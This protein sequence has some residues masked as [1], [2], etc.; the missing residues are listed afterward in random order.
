VHLAKL[1]VPEQTLKLAEFCWPFDFLFLEQRTPLL[2]SHVCRQISIEL[3]KFVWFC[4]FPIALIDF[5]CKLL[6]LFSISS[7]SNGR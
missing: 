5:Y 1:L 7:L 3:Y 6:D 2:S 4:H